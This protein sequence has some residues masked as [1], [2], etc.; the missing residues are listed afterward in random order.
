MR[1]AYTAYYYRLDKE[2]SAPRIDTI[3][4]Y[5]VGLILLAPLRLI[6]PP[7]VRVRYARYSIV[8]YIVVPRVLAVFSL[9]L[10]RALSIPLLVV[11]EA[12]SGDKAVLK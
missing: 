8:P 1:Y 6:R 4:V 5:L 9:L 2:D 3:P 10:I 11:S 7:I 12:L